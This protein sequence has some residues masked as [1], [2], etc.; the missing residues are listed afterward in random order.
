[1]YVDFSAY[2][3]LLIVYKSISLCTIEHEII[4]WYRLYDG[5][6]ELKCAIESTEIKTIYEDTE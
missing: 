2:I 1:M 6:I 5:D 4:F 3:S